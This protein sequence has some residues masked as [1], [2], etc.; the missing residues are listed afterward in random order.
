M[1]FDKLRG[2]YLNGMACQATAS[3]AP[4]MTE[5]AWLFSP[6]NN[7]SSYHRPALGIIDEVILRI[8]SIIGNITIFNAFAVL[9]NYEGIGEGYITITPLIRSG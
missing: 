7:Q 2:A 6:L 5:R 4:T 9:I 1:N 8:Y 3:V